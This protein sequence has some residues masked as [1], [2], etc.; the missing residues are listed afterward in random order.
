MKFTRLLILAALTWVLG[1]AA[2]ETEATAQMTPPL[3]PSPIE[4]FRRWLKMEPAARD[5]E[6]AGYPEEKRTI[7][8]QKLESYEAM[9]PGDREARLQLLELRWYLQPLMSM[10]ATNRANHLNVIPSHLHGAL[11]ARLKHW[12]GLNEATRQEILADPKKR[13]LAMR[14]FVLPRRAQIMPPPFPTDSRAAAP[15]LQAHF[16]RWEHKSPAARAKMSAH[17]AQFFQMP[18]DEQREALNSFPESER[19]EMQKTLDAF[20]QL[21]PETRRACVNSF[22]RFATMSP[23]NRASFLRNAA[24]WQQL[25]AQERAAWRDLVEKVPPLPPVPFPSPPMP[26]TPRRDSGSNVAATGNLPQVN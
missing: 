9:R 5:K 13:E 26:Q 6:L 19:Q 18:G 17:L 7:L 11:K 10:P 2:A 8:R 15:E 12:D 14:Y 23:E 24:R 22:Q 3:P 20:A 4:D 1:I 25:T 21:S 16:K